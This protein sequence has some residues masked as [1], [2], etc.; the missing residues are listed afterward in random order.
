MRWGCL[1]LGVPRAP[2]WGLCGGK[3]ALPPG[4]KGGSLG[5][6]HSSEVL[7]PS[8][9]FL[10]RSQQPIPGWLRPSALDGV[11]HSRSKLATM[12]GTKVA[13]GQGGSNIPP[14]NPRSGLVHVFG[15]PRRNTRK[16]LIRLDRIDI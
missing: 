1:G 12:V 16:H 8:F 15:L 7:R 14:G 2:V 4:G 3:G 9:G 11:F 6:A 13:S 10:S 5:D